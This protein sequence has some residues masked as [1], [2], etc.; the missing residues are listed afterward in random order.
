M[1]RKINNELKQYLEIFASE[2]TID[3]LLPKINKIFNE[4]YTRLELQHYL[5]RN[6]IEYK[7]KNKNKSHEMGKNIPIGS[8][9]TKPDGMV[10]VKTARNKWMY[11]Q[12]LIYE[13]YH[14][15]K[16]KSN[17][18]V[19]FLDGNRNNF[20]IDNLEKV[21]YKEASYIGAF[22]VNNDLIIK[23]KEITKVLLLMAKLNNKANE[24]KENKNE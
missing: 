7:Y 22:K 14:K 5:V 8:E 10:M 13:K 11:K 20:N 3:E 21:D 23:N 4:N 12:R 6:K 17:E 24:L 15:V 2:F 1:R 18:Y 16:L 19:I 9:Y